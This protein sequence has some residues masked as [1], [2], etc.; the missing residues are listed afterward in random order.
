MKLLTRFLLFLAPLFYPVCCFSAEY[1]IDGEVN[2]VKSTAYLLDGQFISVIGTNGEAVI[3]EAAKHTF[4]LV[5]PSLRQQTQIDALKTKEQTESLRQQVLNVKNPKKDSFLYFAVQP[6]YTVKND[7]SNGI[8]TLESP[9]VDYEFKTTPFPDETAA[10]YYDFCDWMCYLNLRLNPYSSMMLTRLAANQFLREKK[11]F[12]THVSS[13]LY[14]KGKS[15]L[16][17]VDLLES[18]HQLSRRLSDEDKKCLDKIFE[19]K[20]TYPVVP[21]EE[22]QKRMAEKKTEK[23]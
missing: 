10:M 4:T 16:S 23:K 15:A 19:A 13:A 2:G 18:A 12:A 7:G 9:W 3:F 8:I 20:K 21:F 6:K 11:Q 17:Q 5:D 22:Y 1:R 14:T